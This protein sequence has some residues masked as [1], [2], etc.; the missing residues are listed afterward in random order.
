ME[1][2]FKIEKPKLN[3][4]EKKK[5]KEK[6]GKLSLKEFS[7]Y[8][9]EVN[10]PKYLYWDKI[11]YK[12]CPSGLEP[13]MFWFLVR[14]FRDMLSVDTLIKNKKGKY[15][16][17]FRLPSTEKILH[18]IDISSGGQI[19]T[20]MSTLLGMKKQKFVSR[21]VLEEAIASSQLEGAN[22]TRQVAKEMIA[23]NREPRNKSERMILNNYKMMTE[24]E[25]DYKNQ[26]LSMDLL[27]EMHRM[28]TKKTMKASEVGRFRKDKDNIV[29]SHPIASRNYITFIPPK[30]SFLKKEIKR[31]IKYAN[32][33]NKK[34][35]FLHPI[36][37]A[38]FIHFWVGYLHPFVDG[39]GRMARAL[40][41]WYLL[42]KNYWTFMYLPISTIIKKAPAQYAMAYVYSEQDSRDLTYFYNFHIRKIVQSLEEFNRYVEKTI[43]ENK[44]VDQLLNGNFS[45]NNRQ[46][47]LIHYL[48]SGKNNY[49]TA[50]SHSTLNR[51]SRQTATKDLKDLEEKGLVYSKKEGRF[52]KY[53]ATEKLLKM[54]QIRR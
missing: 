20:E 52:V 16:R 30:E 19:F 31:F 47:N 14:K 29:I 34:D 7:K 49:S 13:K 8:F 32:D 22:T 39:N 26:D 18:K 17:W 46:K 42:R 54:A 10:E 41:Y 2:I 37:K 15:F 28:L 25:E 27:L 40:F 44:E 51:I 4:S 35:A 33:Q 48:I 45:F 11:K 36:I 43:L 5:A 3:E 6:F 50:T 12:K 23:E 24:L 53:R 9:R 1:E 38:I 21:G